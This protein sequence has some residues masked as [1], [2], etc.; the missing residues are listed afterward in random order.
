MTEAL[1]CV[2]VLARA[3]HLSWQPYAQQLLSVMMLTGPSQVSHGCLWE[4]QHHFAKQHMYPA[5]T[6]PAH[7]NW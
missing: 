1:A 6:S 7:C 2:G 3:L 5:H 4:E